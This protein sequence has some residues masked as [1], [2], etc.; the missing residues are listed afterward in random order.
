MQRVPI[1]CPK[2]TASKV[3]VGGHE[4]VSAWFPDC[5]SGRSGGGGVAGR[6]FI[7]LFTYYDQ[8][9]SI[10]IESPCYDVE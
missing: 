6:S 1:R 4:G 7:H 3:K 9:S 5:P 2:G 8:E 10:V